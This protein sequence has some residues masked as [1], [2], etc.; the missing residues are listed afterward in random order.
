MVSDAATKVDSLS[1]IIILG[2]D[3]LFTNS[4][5]ARRKV[6]SGKFCT[7]SKWTARE[8]AKVKRQI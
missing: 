1:D 7:I 4:L 5:N 3:L 8:L 6:S 2:R